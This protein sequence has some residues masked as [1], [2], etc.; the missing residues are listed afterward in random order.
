MVDGVCLLAESRQMQPF[1]GLE[2]RLTGRS[3]RRALRIARIQSSQC[4]LLF[5]QLAADLV[6]QQTEHAQPKRE[7]AEQ[8]F[9][10]LVRLQL[11]RT[12]RQRSSFQASEASF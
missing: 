2:Q 10:P 1:K 7:Q 6:F 4:L 5:S 12:H 9:H 3:S 8:A 11:Y